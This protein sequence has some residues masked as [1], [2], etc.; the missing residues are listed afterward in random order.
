MDTSSP[1]QDTNDVDSVIV[2]SE[3]ETLL[4]ELTARS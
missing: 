2:S 4:I 3:K 1:Q